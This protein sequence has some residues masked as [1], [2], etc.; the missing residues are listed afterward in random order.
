MRDEGKSGRE[1]CCGKAGWH[2]K[3]ISVVRP[4]PC[5]WRFQ[6]WDDLDLDGLAGDFDVFV[7]DVDVDLGADAELAFLV[8]AWLDGKTNAGGDETR[9]ARLEVIDV[10]AVAVAFLADRVAGAMGE[11][12]AV[13]GALDHAARD[14]VDFRAV[15]SFSFTHIFADEFRRGIPR[16]PDDVEDA[17]VFFRH[18][19]SDEAGPG[20][21][22]VDRARLAE[23]ANDIEQDEVAALDRRR[24]LAR[25]EIMRV[26]GICVHGDDAVLFRHSFLVEPPRDELLDV[27]FGDRLFSANAPADLGECFHQD[28]VQ[29]V[30]RVDVRLLL[31]RGQDRF[32]LLD[33]FRA[34]DDL[35]AKRPD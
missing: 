19:V 28:A 6:N 35:D 32:E 13:P 3:T 18:G 10:H 27:V 30:G 4:Q 23:F 7:A 24:R 1:S 5:L 15:N 22:G 20:L 29:F 9:I 25:W 31:G 33:Q 8:D 2:V 12:F 34:G 11:L 26:R 21:V 17:D 16:F 14:I